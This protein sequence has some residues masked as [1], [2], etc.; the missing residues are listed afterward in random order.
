MFKGSIV[1]IITPFKDGK[2]DEE[3]LRELV[4][5]QI[6]NGTDGIVPCGT[7]GEAS[8]LDYEEHDRVIEIVVQ[9]TKKRVP[10]IAGTGSNS[11]EEAIEITRH[12]K[13]VGADGALLVT[14][15]CT[16]TTR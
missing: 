16:A 9:Q 3:S 1:A 4:E 14:P 13:Q 11:T 6:E 15:Y 8:T 2:I 7:T 5:F 10:V 12:A